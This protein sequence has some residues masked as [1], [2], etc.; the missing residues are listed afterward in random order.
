MASVGAFGLPLISVGMTDAS[1]TRRAS[2][3]STRSSAST[4]APM[5][6]VPA[7]WKMECA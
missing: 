6:Q 2:M 7:G 5:A 3:P 4:T 1:T